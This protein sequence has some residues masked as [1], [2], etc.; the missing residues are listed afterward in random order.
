MLTL[1]L[2]C[3]KQSWI[4]ITCYLLILELAQNNADI[5][6]AVPQTSISQTWHFPDV[7]TSNST[8]LMR[9]LRVEVYTCGS[10]QGLC[11]RY[12]PGQS[13][14]LYW[15]FLSYCWRVFWTMSRPILIGK[16]ILLSVLHKP[17]RKISTNLQQQD[18]QESC[19][20]SQDSLI[21]RSGLLLGE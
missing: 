6:Y 7:W 14:S 18:W 3:L 4:G 9:I 11:A 20:V 12:C 21:C 13:L 10:C 19:W 15:T 17:V 5:T 8:A 16:M 1:Y 2:L